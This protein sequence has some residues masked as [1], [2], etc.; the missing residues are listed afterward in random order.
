MN[1]SCQILPGIKTIY[2]VACENLP[3]RIDL[4]AL[5]GINVALLTELHEITFF[6][7]PE[8]KCVTEKSKNGWSQK[9]TLK[10]FSCDT[11]PFYYNIAFVVVDIQG[12][13]Y[14]IGAKERPYP[15]LTMGKTAGRRSER[16]GTEYE[17][18]HNA[19]RTMVKCLL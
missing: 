7:E 2:W 15:V 8:C 17:I 1:N 6:G 11:L 14:I 16:A 10:F 3:A 12:E 9:A 18:T 5:S 13:A 4:S 19:V